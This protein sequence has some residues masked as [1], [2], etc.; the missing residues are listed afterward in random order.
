MEPLVRLY[1]KD[2][3]SSTVRSFDGCYGY[4]EGESRFKK[5]KYV[6]RAT[7]KNGNVMWLT[8]PQ[9]MFKLL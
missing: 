8:L 7:D 3:S 9:A 1:T 4:I 5:D 6:V 2:S